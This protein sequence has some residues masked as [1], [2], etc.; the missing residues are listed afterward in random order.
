ML[1]VE[2]VECAEPFAIASSKLSIIDSF[3]IGY[4]FDLMTSSRNGGMIEGG[5]FPV[6]ADV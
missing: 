6:Q 5:S 3:V 2:A 1:W 4:D